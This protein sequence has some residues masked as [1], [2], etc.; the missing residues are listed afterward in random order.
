MERN[1]QNRKKISF[2][3]SCAKKTFLYVHIN[4]AGVISQEIHLWMRGTDNTHTNTH[5]AT[6]TCTYMLREG[7]RYVTYEINNTAGYY[8]LWGILN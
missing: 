2:I 7:P 1:A 3:M 8:V 4:L 5:T 6:H